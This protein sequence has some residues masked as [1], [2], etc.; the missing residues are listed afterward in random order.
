MQNCFQNLDRDELLYCVCIWWWWWWCAQIC[1]N[2]CC[3]TLVARGICFNPSMYHLWMWNRQK[4]A[5]TTMF[6][7]S[8]FTAKI[9]F[10]KYL[11]CIHYRQWHCYQYPE[12]WQNEAKNMKINE[13]KTKRKREKKPMN[14]LMKLIFKYKPISINTLG[15]VPCSCVW[16]SYEHK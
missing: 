13:N 3:T 4:P 14:M 8:A 10:V 5:T 2:S 6:V 1:L 15:F 16:A 12:Q 11:S 9:L 7:M